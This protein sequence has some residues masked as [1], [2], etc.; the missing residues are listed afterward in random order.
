[1]GTR[2]PLDEDGT[3][4][5]AKPSGGCAGVAPPAFKTSSGAPKKEQE[6]AGPLRAVLTSPRGRRIERLQQHVREQARILLETTLARWKVSPS[7][8]MSPGPERLQQLVHGRRSNRTAI[9]RGR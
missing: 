8:K 2:L 1:M 6:P 9:T 7:L 5:N 4:P 3:A